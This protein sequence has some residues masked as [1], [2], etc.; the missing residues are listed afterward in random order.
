[1]CF[2]GEQDRFARQ[3]EFGGEIETHADLIGD[4]YPKWLII[5][6]D[7]GKVGQDLARTFRRCHRGTC[8]PATC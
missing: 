5:G 6:F 2:R 3:H 8:V 4:G 7:F 1:M